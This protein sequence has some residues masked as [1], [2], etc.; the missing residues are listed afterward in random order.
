MAIIELVK[1]EDEGYRKA[2]RRRKPPSEMAR[3]VK[4]GPEAKEN[5]GKVV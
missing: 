3:K 5:G 1:G 4:N 2:P